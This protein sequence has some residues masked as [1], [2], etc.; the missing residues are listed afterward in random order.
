MCE[1]DIIVMSRRELKRLQVV[2]KTIE[3]GL[4]QVEAAN[5]LE[6]SVRQIG[7]LV[8]RIESEGDVGVVHRLRGK[9]SNFRIGDD[10]RKKVIDLYRVKYKGFGPTLF[11]EKL[12]EDEDL[13]LSAETVRQLLIGS[14]DWAKRRKVR[15]HR[16]WRERSGHYGQ[17]QQ[18][19]GSH[20]D[21]LE[22]RGP[23]LV[24]M[25]YIDDATGRVHGRF[26]DYEGTVPA[27]DS[28]RRYVRKYGVPQSVY[29]DKHT[30]YKST[31]KLTIEDELNGRNPK[32]QFER[33]LSELGVN[34]I[35]ANSPQAK[36]RVERLF[37]TLQDRLVKE[38]RLRGIKTKEEANK[39]L[40]IYF[41]KHSKKFGVIAR[42]RED[43]HIKLPAGTNLERIL[44]IK[45]ERTL[46]N[47]F[48]VS[49]DKKVY[50]VLE[51]VKAD[52]VMLEER[53]DGSL[54]LYCNNESLKYKEIQTSPLKVKALQVS[55]M[56]FTR[57]R[58]KHIPAADHPWRKPFKKPLNSA[59]FSQAI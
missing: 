27:M 54:R 13:K 42:E 36:G 41:P 2:K 26:Y 11:C 43:M 30:T 3:G 57:R 59:V 5:V 4:K 47:D 31:A 19:D 46:R 44:C 8:R 49:K 35:H 20:H 14:G 22:G 34:V 1:K 32:S 39:F 50:Q 53:I 40:E 51:A 38:M 24:L 9:A 10:K 6:L 55:D 18:M 33:A 52:K 16:Q 25:A 48:T 21:W 56:P 28:F 45:T 29:L 15:K 58:K 37:K 12:T 17:M 7:R 23:W